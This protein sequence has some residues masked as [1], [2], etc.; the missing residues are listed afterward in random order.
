M[1]LDCIA[2]TIVMSCITVSN[3]ERCQVNY[4]VEKSFNYAITELI[5]EL[6]ND[7]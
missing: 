4:T 3:D 5:I 7:R 2:N 6:L 1:S